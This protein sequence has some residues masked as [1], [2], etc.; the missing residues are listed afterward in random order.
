M[1]LVAMDAF[2]SFEASGHAGSIP[3]L[4]GNPAWRGSAADHRLSRM[5][6]GGIVI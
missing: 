5:T 2:G 3:C 4:L 6:L 1:S